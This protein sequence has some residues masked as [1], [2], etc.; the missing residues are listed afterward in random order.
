MAERNGI[1]TGGKLPAWVFVSMP[2]IFILLV[3]VY[4]FLVLVHGNFSL[5]FFS[6]I[7]GNSPTA[8][9]VRRGIW[10]SITQGV[11]S[12]LAS[13]VVGLPLGIFLG[14]YEFRL[15]RALNSLI[16]VPFFLPS[17]IVVFAV[18]SG[19]GNGSAASSILPF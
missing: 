16:L 13:F 19:F 5:S 9:L 10:N 15:K 7:T 12:A 2:T 14:R 17:L 3:A 1:I 6:E 8:Q 4:P 11:L 18:L